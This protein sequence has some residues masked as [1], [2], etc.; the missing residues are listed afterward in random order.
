MVKQ[1]IEPSQAVTH[2]LSFD[3]DKQDGTRKILCDRIDKSRGTDGE[4][5]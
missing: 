1:T 2:Q 5:N 4:T 3:G